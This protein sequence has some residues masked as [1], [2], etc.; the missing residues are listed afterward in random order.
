[1]T[2]KK[3]NPFK[4]N[5]HEIYYNLINCFVAGALVFLGSLSNGNLTFKGFC[6]AL[7]TFTIVFL[8][9]FKNYWDGEKGEY[10][11]NLF[12]FIGV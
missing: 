8:T 6:F 3:I 5:K 4:A 2:T 9:K 11:H 12:N 10:S 7:L 1:M